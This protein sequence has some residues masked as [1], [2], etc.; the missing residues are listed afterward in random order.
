[1]RKTRNTGLVSSIIVNGSFVTGKPDPNDIDLILV[2]PIGH[3]FSA[4]L[5]PFEYNVLSRRHVRKHHGFDILLAEE[6]QPE[7]TEYIEFFTQ[8]RGVPGRHKGL[9]RVSL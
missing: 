3:E 8:V 4:E 6:G 9:V 1:V 2:L 7:L 5:R